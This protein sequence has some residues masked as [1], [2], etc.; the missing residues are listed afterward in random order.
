MEVTAELNK[1]P[2]TTRTIRRK[3]QQI[4]GPKNRRVVVLGSFDTSPYMDFMC[5]RLAE[6]GYT[7]FTSLYTYKLFKSPRGSLEVERVDN[8]EARDMRIPMV[9][10]LEIML[11]EAEKAIVLYSV[12]G[13]HYIETEWLS[14]GHWSVLGIAL[15]RALKKVQKV[16]ECFLSLSKIDCSVCIGEPPIWD[17]MDEKN[18]E[19]SKQCW[20][21]FIKQ[22]ISKD[23]IERF[24][25]N[26]DRMLLV[27]L[28]NLDN[29]N[30]LLK[31][32]SSG[33]IYK[34]IRKEARAHRHV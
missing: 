14:K 28:D 32:W 11:Q 10:Y 7:A 4:Y 25:L 9:K 34:Q 21:P 33:D 18:S 24:M 31:A 2:K 5:C 1:E 22:E 19:S 26:K 16:E 17:C 15:V 3:L 29:V 27:S 20:C 30:G 6:I 23:V 8:N 12:C 13:A